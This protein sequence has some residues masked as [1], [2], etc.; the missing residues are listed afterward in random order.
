[1]ARKKKPQ[2]EF[3]PDQP[4][5]I[6]SKSRSACCVLVALLVL[7]KAKQ[8]RGSNLFRATYR[9]ITNQT[10]L[11]RR[12]TIGRALRILE[13]TG[14]ISRKNFWDRKKKK[15]VLLVSILGGY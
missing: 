11:Q 4:A 2:V 9:E 10:D 14:W 6:Q 3:P 5:E 15:R 7:R 12:N 13:L 8:V 1:M